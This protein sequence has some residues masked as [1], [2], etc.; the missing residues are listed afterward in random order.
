MTDSDQTSVAILIRFRPRVRIG[1][2]TSK[3]ALPGFVRFLRL[4]AR[5]VPTLAILAAAKPRADPSPRSGTPCSHVEVAL[6]YLG[7]S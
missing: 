7:V 1:E 5:R 4:Q 3:P 2:T 6:E